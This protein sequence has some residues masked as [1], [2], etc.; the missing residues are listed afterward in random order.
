MF[1]IKIAIVGQ[2]AI[3]PRHTDAVLKTP[4]T[5][6]ACIV[7]PHPS[8]VHGAAKYDCPVFVSVD[9]MLEDKN[10]DFDAAI[11]CTPNHTHVAISKQLLQAGKHVLCEKPICVDVASGRE[12]VR[13]CSGMLRSQL[14]KIHRSDVL[15]TASERYL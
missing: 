3:G 2:G 8:A 6:L 10:V 5:T 9:A 14:A 7:D 13:A 12:L 1:N 15:K 11:V 4:G